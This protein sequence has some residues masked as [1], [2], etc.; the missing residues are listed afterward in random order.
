LSNEY[1]SEDGDREESQVVE[2]AR[3]AYLR[4]DKCLHP[5]IQEE[6]GKI[7]VDGEHMFNL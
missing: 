7:M 4:V 6:M 5:E 2:M 1:R 3:N